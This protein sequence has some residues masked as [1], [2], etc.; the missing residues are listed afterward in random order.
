MI[1]YSLACNKGHEFEA[2]FRDSAAYDKQAAGG[3]VLCPDCGSRK[4][5]KAPMAPRLVSG[6]AKEKAKEKAEESKRQAEAMAMLRE[7]REHVEKNAD[8]VGDK[9]AEEARRIH[10]GETEKRSIYGEAN[11][12]DAKELAEEGVEFGV[13]PWVP[14]GN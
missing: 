7:I 2:W 1:L 14:R 3:K 5:K 10:Y 4:V 11:E 12:S 13:V 8:Y 6:E 9:F